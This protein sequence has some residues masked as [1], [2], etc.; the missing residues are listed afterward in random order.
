MGLIAYLGS[1]G[2]RGA[3]FGIKFRGSGHDGGPRRSFLGY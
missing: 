2:G 3:M 1:S